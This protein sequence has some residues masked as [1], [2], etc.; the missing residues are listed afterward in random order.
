MNSLVEQYIYSN[1]ELDIENKFD[2]IYHHSK[3]TNKMKR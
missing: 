1:K 2:D 3:N